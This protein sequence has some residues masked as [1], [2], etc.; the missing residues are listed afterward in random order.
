M[1]KDGIDLIE[2]EMSGWGAAGGGGD[3]RRERKRGE[4]GGGRGRGEGGEALRMT[5][6]PGL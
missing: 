5:V 3:R 1:V 6:S 2:E 4:E